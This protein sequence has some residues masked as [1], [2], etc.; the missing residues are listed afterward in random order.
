[1]LSPS[2]TIPTIHPT[3]YVPRG[4]NILRLIFHDQFP[5]F[6]QSYDSLYAKDYGKLR[7]QRISHVAERFESCGDYTNGI[8]RIQCS[9]PACGLEYFRPFSCKG[10]YLC[11][12]CT[13]KRT[14]MFAEHLEEQLLTLPHRQ[15][16][17]SIPKPSASSSVTTRGCSLQFFLSS[18]P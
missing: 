9:N 17:F 14:L 16:V 3:T 13:Q 7:L 11:P 2:S 1:V 15:F 4:A 5:A 18:S 10:F 12:S 8:A 6:V